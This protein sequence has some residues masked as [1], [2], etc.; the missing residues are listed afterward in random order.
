M[1]DL[2]RFQC[3]R[4][5]EIPTDYRMKGISWRQEC[6]P[7][8]P[9]RTVTPRSYV[10]IVKDPNLFLIKS[11][12]E[13]DDESLACFGEGE[14]RVGSTEG[15]WTTCENCQSYQPASTLHWTGSDGKCPW[16][17]LAIDLLNATIKSLNAKTEVERTHALSFH[18]LG[19]VIAKPASSWPRE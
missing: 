13:A 7:R 10:A 8:R 1:S 9:L 4:I 12:W 15:E 18:L 5:A 6:D 3:M 17:C 16:V 11:K 19:S 14:R 2:G